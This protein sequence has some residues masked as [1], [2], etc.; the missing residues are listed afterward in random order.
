MKTQSDA[1]GNHH[2]PTL[3]SFPRGPVLMGV[4]D[5]LLVVVLAVAGLLI[6][7]VQS[8]LAATVVRRVNLRR[9]PAS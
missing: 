9:R 5:V 7:L 4:L 2:E 1:D 6:L 8:W 3:H